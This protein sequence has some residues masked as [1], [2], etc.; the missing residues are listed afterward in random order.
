MLDPFS[1]A[2]SGRTEGR[3]ERCDAG[4]QTWVHKGAG[5]RG[6]VKLTER[7]CRNLLNQGA[8]VSL[9]GVGCPW[10]PAEES[11]SSA[12]PLLLSQSCL[13]PLPCGFLVEL[14]RKRAV[15]NNVSKAVRLCILWKRNE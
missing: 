2:T 6:T 1:A 9:D 7:G 13:V 15:L 10:C 8:G 5:T 3:A 11:T 4:A 12:A 14:Y